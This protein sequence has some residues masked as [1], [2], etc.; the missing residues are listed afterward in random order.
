MT[1]YL[2]KQGVNCLYYAF[3]QH[4]D[5]IHNCVWLVCC[6]TSCVCVCLYKIKA[7]CSLAGVYIDYLYIYYTHK[8]DRYKYK[9]HR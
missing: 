4:Y 7:T 2:E 1:K 8:H 9:L 6:Y 3:Q 5:F